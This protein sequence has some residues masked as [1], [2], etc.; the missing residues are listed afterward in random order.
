M[1]QVYMQAVDP[2]FGLSLEFIY[3][4]MANW[5]GDVM[6]VNIPFFK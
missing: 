6:E 2:E 1:L 4:Y 3:L 5:E